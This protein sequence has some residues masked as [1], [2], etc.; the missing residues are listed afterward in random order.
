MWVV[1]E[2]NNLFI[3]FR[4]RGGARYH[5]YLAFPNL[6][7]FTKWNNRKLINNVWKSIW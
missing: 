2:L 6:N 4:I 7:E 3:F 5:P 1:G